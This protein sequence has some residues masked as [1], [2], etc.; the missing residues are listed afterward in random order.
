MALWTV[1]LAQ[2][3]H[4]GSVGIEPPP[5]VLSDQGGATA[6]RRYTVCRFTVVGHELHDPECSGDK[7]WFLGTFEFDP[8]LP[9][10]SVEVF[11]AAFDDDQAKNSG[12]IPALQVIRLLIES[13]WGADYG[14]LNRFRVYGNEKNKTIARNGERL[15]NDE[16]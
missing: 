13:N 1:Q 14:C 16:E 9:R 10:S 12:T 8:T 2:S 5:P 3:I 11:A 4:M 6:V 15:K 7:A